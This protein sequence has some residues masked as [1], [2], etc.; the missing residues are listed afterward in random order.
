M[1]VQNF[2]FLPSKREQNKKTQKQAPSPEQN[3]PPK[4][5]CFGMAAGRRE[6]GLHME[7]ILLFFHT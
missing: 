6:A 5:L 7:I 1:L 4:A 2:P 3:T